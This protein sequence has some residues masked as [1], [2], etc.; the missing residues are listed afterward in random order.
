MKGEIKNMFMADLIIVD[1]LCDKCKNQ[2]ESWAEEPCES[3]KI[4]VSNYEYKGV[5]P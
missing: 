4:T 5:K 2:R 3:C 1:G